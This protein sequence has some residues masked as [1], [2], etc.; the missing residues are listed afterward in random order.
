MMNFAI[1]LCGI[2]AG[3]TSHL[4][5]FIHGEWH[6]HSRSIIGAHATIAALVLGTLQRYLDD[7]LA[8]CT[9]T[10]TLS[11]WYL[12]SLFASIA[13]Y[14]TMF[15]KLVNFPGPRLA[16]VSKFWHIYHARNSTNY[17]VMQRLYEKYGTVVRTGPNEITIFHPSAIEL[18]DGAH[19]TNSKDVWYDVLQP[20]TSAIFTRNAQDH[21]D[22]RR[23]WTQSLSTKAM[24]EFR[25][26]IYQQALNLVQCI[27]ELS[28]AP[29]NINDV[30]SW[31]SFDAMGDVV[32]GKSFGMMQE[33]VTH[34]AIIHQKRALALLGPISDAVWIAQ[35]AFSFVPFL[36]KVKSW[37]R[38]VSYC[39]ERMAR[40]ME[41]QTDEK[42]D[43]ASWFIDEYHNLSE[44]RDLQ[45]RQRLL[46]GTAVS[47]IVA[48]SDTTRA[49][50]IA[51]WWYLA[52]YPEHAEKIRQEIET[53]DIGDANVLAG[54]PHLN[55]VIQEILRL[56]PPAMTGGGR[57]TGPQG[58]TVDNV[59]IPAGTKVTAPKYVI[60]RMENAFVHPDEFIPERWYSRPDL[61]KDKRAFGPFSFG[62]RQC[63]GK[64]LAYAEL[65]LVT[66]NVL[67]NFNVSFSPGY[68]E[69]TM[70]RDMKDQVTA[71]PGQVLCTFERR[72]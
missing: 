41:L 61:V 27:Q 26:R 37:M 38:M 11:A 20:R 30:M 48:G 39:E 32:F 16:A 47:A 42:A 9:Y 58:L 3:V 12:I 24:D 64:V 63:V 13:V 15:H 10:I 44:V 54:L 35:L 69:E 53:V 67:R 52:K 31:F 34:D 43:M 49:S 70:W 36:G 4:G 51:T 7:I 28:S 72:I 56:V 71:Q 2:V 55:G 22:R 17:L 1:P 8:A 65:R 25:P 59:F 66:A 23:V 5:F 6:L 50:L 33:K 45:S 62:S 18:L 57:I 68:D 46:G 21:R 19:N 29:V 40:R 60:K 14:R